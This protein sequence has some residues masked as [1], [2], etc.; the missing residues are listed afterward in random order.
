MEAKVRAWP[1]SPRVEGPHYLEGEP[2]VGG[3]RVACRQAG[4]QARPLLET[5][6]SSRHPDAGAD[7]EALV[8]GG[9]LPRARGA[10]PQRT[11]LRARNLVRPPTHTS[12][13]Y[14]AHTRIPCP[15]SYR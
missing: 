15:L 8:Q 5:E 4:G 3:R 12:T 14:M 6:D 9:R 10:S 13:P 7:G 1:S 11:C 2:K